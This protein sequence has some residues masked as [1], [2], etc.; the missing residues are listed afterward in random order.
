MEQRRAVVIGAGIG[1]LAAAVAL[2][3]TGW[4][5]TVLERLQRLDPAGAGLAIAPNALRAL[6]RVGVG[7][8]VRALA[9]ARGDVGLRRPDGRWLSRTSA[10]AIRTRFGEP[11]VV[12]ARSAVVDALRAV[13]PTDAVRTGTEVTSVEQGTA[14]APARVTVGDD[15]PLAADLVV[16]A[17]GLRSAARQAAFPGHAGPRYAGYTTW[18]WLAPS[19]GQPYRPAETWGRGRLFGAMP[20]VDGRVYCWASSVAA[21]GQEYQDDHA[22]LVRLYADWHDPIPALVSAARDLTLLRLDIEELPTPLPAYHRDRLALVGD[23]AHAMT[24]FLGQ[25]ACQAIEDAVTLAAVLGDVPAGAVPAA[26][27][28]YSGTRLPRVTMIAERSR[29]VGRLAQVTS[30][31]AVLARDAGLRL[32]DRLVPDLAVRQMVPVVD[33]EP[34]ALGSGRLTP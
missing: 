10:D 9:A 20:L 3:R 33:V 2:R 25:G 29:R 7:D 13:L 8:Q 22:E 28:S 32:A 30:P 16:A 5:V 12:A 27:A 15:A 21:A 14:G 31:L 26:L 11:M 17:D 18:R 23:A 6:D 4:Q 34:P 24:P 19:P 1:G